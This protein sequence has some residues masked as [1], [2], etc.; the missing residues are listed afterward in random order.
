MPQTD[1]A[2]SPA[3]PVL[4]RILTALILLFLLCASAGFLYENVSEARDR[5]FNPMSGRRFDVGGYKMH[6]DC[7]G[8]GSPAVILDSGLGDTYISWRKVQPQIAKSTRVCSYDRAG[9]GYSD[10]SPRPRTSRSIAEELHA[11]LQAASVPP[12]YVLVGHSMAGY[13]VRIYSSL[14]PKEVAGMV[15]VDASHPDQENR[16]PPE[17]K[18]MEASW[19]REAEF[20]AYTMPFGVPR[21]MGLCD[22]DVPQ[23]TAECNFHTAQGAVAELKTFSESAQE[24]GQTGLLGDIPLEVLSHDPDKPSAELP[25][26][27]AK[28]TNEAWEKMQEELAHLSTRGVQRVVKGSSHYIQIDDPQVVIDAVRTMVAEVHQPPPAGAKSP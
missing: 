9:L 5:R 2:S 12:P 26:D 23:R 10:S 19:M 7:I 11:L 28:P 15:L 4:R 6:I 3:R 21:A 22:D 13:D 18:N 24:A 20:L 8:E 1:H 27:V 14:Y 16:F 17:L 25:P